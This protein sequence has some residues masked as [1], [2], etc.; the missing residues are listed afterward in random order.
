MSN[1]LSNSSWYS[2]ISALWPGQALSLEIEKILFEGDSDFQHILLFQSKSYGKV[3]VLDGAIQLTERDEFSYQEMICHLPLLSHPNP[4]KICVIGGGDGAVLTQI[5]KHKSVEEV[6]LCDIDSMVIA[7]SKEF[8]PQFHP[9]FN[10]PR[11]RVIVAD[12]VK[13]LEQLPEPLFDVII[14]DSSDPIGPASVLFEESFYEIARKALKPEGIVCSQSES[15]WLHVELIQKMV[16]FARN[17]YPSVEYASL[18]IPTYPNGQIGILLC[19]KG[20]SCQKPKRT[21][22]EAFSKAEDVN[23]LRY[24]DD[25]VHAS[26]FALPRFARNALL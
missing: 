23:S 26:A 4:K 8:F 17:L 22:Q 16:K 21:A 14:V 10:D 19:S 25:L 9:G 20:G 7:K 1:L 15:M 11:V 6:H 5:I 13:Y 3:L 2:E 18:Y 12:G 24:Y